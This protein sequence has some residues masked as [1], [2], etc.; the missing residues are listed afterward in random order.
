MIGRSFLGEPDADGTL[1]RKK[2]LELVED[3]EGQFEQ[4]PTRFQFKSV[5]DATGV[6]EIIVYNDICTL[7]EEQEEKEDG[8]WMWKKIAEVPTPSSLRMGIWGAYMGT[9][10]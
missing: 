1:R 10:P 4:D 9:Y 3:Y 6:E 2:I 8:T 5:T 7:I